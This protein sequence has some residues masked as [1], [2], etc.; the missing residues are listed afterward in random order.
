MLKENVFSIVL[1]DGK[2]SLKVEEGLSRLLNA[3]DEEKEFAFKSI[4]RETKKI[5]DMLESDKN[6]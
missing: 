6:N 3:S 2:F 4:E 5:I 1:K